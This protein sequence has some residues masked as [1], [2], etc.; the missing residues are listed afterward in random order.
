M[1]SLCASVEIRLMN[2]LTDLFQFISLHINFCF[3]KVY[4]KSPSAESALND[5]HEMIVTRFQNQSGIIYCLSQRDT[6]DVAREL[7][8]RGVQ[9][10][11]Y[12]ANMD[13]KSRSQVHA[14]WSSNRIQVSCSEM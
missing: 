11:C 4:P 13:A 12:H 10:N 6:E 3:S 7:C 14:Y 8:K 1:N 5:I 9:A 2:H